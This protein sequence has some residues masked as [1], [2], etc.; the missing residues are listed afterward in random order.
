MIAFVGV[1]AGIAMIVFGLYFLIQSLFSQAGVSGVWRGN[2]TVWGLGVIIFGVLIAAA[3][4]VVGF[5]DIMNLSNAQIVRWAEGIYNSV[6]S[7]SA[8]SLLP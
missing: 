1:V 7:G 3:F 5:R 8:P 2:Q 4:V 6:F